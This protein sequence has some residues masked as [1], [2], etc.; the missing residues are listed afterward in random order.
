M[1]PDNTLETKNIDDISD[2]V[3]TVVGTFSQTPNANAAYIL[4]TSTLETTKWRVISVKENDNCTFT[5][6][7][8]SHEND[9]Y[10]FVEDGSPLSTRS[11]STLTEKKAAPQGLRAEEQIVE[12]NNRAVTKIFLD[13]Q[14]VSGAS[15]YRIYYRYENGDFILTEQGGLIDVTDS[16]EPNASSTLFVGYIDQMDITEGP[17]TS[18]I[19]VVLESKLL[20]L[21]RSRVLRYTSAIQKA[22]YTGDKGFDFVD[23]LQG[24]TFNWGRK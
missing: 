22:L 14:N 4:E 13:W 19:S 7:A 21:E 18:S 2:N 15:K 20:E 16:T 5:I 11:I 10:S 24:Q 6:T 3:I 9:K 23:E 1:L 17:E 8:L 12:I